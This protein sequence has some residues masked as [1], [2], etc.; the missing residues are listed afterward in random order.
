MPTNILNSALSQ[1]KTGHILNIYTT[2]DIF[3]VKINRKK[4]FHILSEANGTTL[5]S[6]SPQ[7]IRNFIKNNSLNILKL[8]VPTASR[9]FTIYNS[10]HL[11]KIKSENNYLK[12][13][14]NIVTRSTQ[15]LPSTARNIVRKQVA[16]PNTR[17]KLMKSI[18]AHK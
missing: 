3:Q 15:H 7:A 4:Q 12:R 18:R 8:R 10:N 17:Q 13:K 6:P 5:A 14:I 9:Q 1:L 16:K 11:R 2:D